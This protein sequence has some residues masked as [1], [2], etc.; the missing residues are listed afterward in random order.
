MSKKYPF[1]LILSCILALGLANCKS[2]QKTAHTNVPTGGERLTKENLIEKITARQVKAEWMSGDLDLDYKGKP[3]SVGASGVARYRKDSVIWL[4]VRK[5]GLVN[6]ARA[7]VTKDSIFLVNYLQSSYVA[8]DLKYISQKFNL[9]ANFDVLQNLLLGNPVWLIP[10]ASLEFNIDSSGNY[11][12]QGKDQRWQTTYI[13]DKEAFR[14]KQMQFIE[15]AT[16]KSLTVV[17]DKYQTLPDGQT[18]PFSRDFTLASPE[19][20]LVKLNMTVTGTPEM[21]VPKTIK[22]EIPTH[23]SKMD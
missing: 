20:G 18:F 8:T 17:Y 13:I 15:T 9:P 2:T 1:Y 10:Q 11:R 3:M 4:N 14:I 16:T 21:D 19:T 22:F 12:L 6:V 7:Q 5:F 23:Y